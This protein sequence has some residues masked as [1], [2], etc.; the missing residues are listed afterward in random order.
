MTTDV[1]PATSSSLS[2]LTSE[3]SPLYTP[4]NDRKLSKEDTTSGLELNESYQQRKPSERSL[5]TSYHSL[6]P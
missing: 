5:I 6:V 3:L 4:S 2:R 1:A